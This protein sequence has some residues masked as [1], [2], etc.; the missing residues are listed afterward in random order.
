MRT[1]IFVKIPFFTGVVSVSL[2]MGKTFGCFQEQE[3]KKKKSEKPSNEESEENHIQSN[4]RHKIVNRSA[5][6]HGT[7]KVMFIIA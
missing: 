7:T 4:N 3:Q 6:Q 1:S 5:R 2:D